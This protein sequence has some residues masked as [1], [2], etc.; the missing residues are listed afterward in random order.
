MSTR[1][2][3]ATLHTASR[4][5]RPHRLKLIPWHIGFD[6][7]LLA[8]QPG[9]TARG[10]SYTTC[11][12]YFCPGSVGDGIALQRITVE[13][14]A[15]NPHFD[16]ILLVKCNPPNGGDTQS[17]WI[18]AMRATEAHLGATYQ[19]RPLYFIL[20][21]GLHWLPFYWDPTNPMPAGQVL[22]MK[23]DGDGVE[24]GD[25][26]VSRWYFVRPEVRAPP[27]VDA[28]HVDADGVVSTDRA[29]SLDC[30]TVAEPLVAGEMPRLANQVDLDCLEEFLGVVERNS[31]VDETKWN[32]V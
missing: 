28:E 32:E 1:S 3:E 14:P 12:Q 8:L 15:V 22:K 4:L 20:A 25:K 19:D 30:I 10:I 5:N 16:N 23:G 18:S 24:G 29:R 7:S 11:V 2:S 21:V 9:Q 31:V 17:Q 13:L 27:G 26:D 6:Q